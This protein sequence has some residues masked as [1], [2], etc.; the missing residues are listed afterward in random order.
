MIKKEA[1]KILK[2][3]DPTIEVQY[4]WNIKMNTISE[5]FRKY[6]NTVT[7]KQEINELRKAA[8]LSTAHI[9]LKVL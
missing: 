3:K 1:E 2:Y 4:V 5:S 8:I 6:L 9:L 7:G